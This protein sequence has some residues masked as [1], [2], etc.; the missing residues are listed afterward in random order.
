MA[1]KKPVIHARDH[2]KGGADPLDIV[3]P[4]S[5]YSNAIINEPV[6]GLV[7]YWKLDELGNTTTDAVDS[8]GNGHTGTYAIGGGFSTTATHPT[9]G[10]AA[11]ADGT[12]ASFDG[13]LDNVGIGSSVPGIQAFGEM[14][15]ECWIETEQTSHADD[16]IH[17]LDT[18]VG[19]I[20]MSDD[21]VNRFFRLELV[22]STGKLKFTVFD[23]GSVSASLTSTTVVNDGAR[24]YIV[25]TYDGT[26]MNIYIDGALDATSAPGLDGLSVN[27]GGLWVGSSFWEASNFY[28]H[29]HFQGVIDEFALYTVALPADSVETHFLIGSTAS[30]PPSGTAG[31]DLTGNYP[32]P[33]LVDIGDGAETVGDSTHYPIVTIDDKGRVTHM[34]AQSVPS[35]A[36]SGAAG[37]AL[38]GTYPNPGIAASVAG[39]GLAESSDVLSVNVD[40]STIEINSD[41]LRVKDSGI[42]AAKLSLLV[43]DLLAAVARVKVSLGGV[44]KGTRRQINFIAGTNITIT[45]T[46]DSSNEKV[47]VQ[48]DASGGGGGGGGVVGFGKQTADRVTSGTSYAGGID[49]LSSDFSF[50]ADGT[51]SYVVELLAPGSTVTVTQQ[52]QFALKLDSAQS[53]FMGYQTV[54]SGGPSQVI[55]A[56]GVITPAAGSHTVNVRFWLTSAANGTIYAGTSL[57]NSTILVMV[58]Q[59]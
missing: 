44:L 22:F 33:E 19:T 34:A 41:T 29:S 39:A 50:T 26:D 7:L 14:S 58:T 16:A 8:S 17:C 20:A 32:D 57:T 59:L 3:F 35:G 42:T 9:L 52:L 48:I 18:S 36:P 49:L 28:L 38:D 11:L 15:V 31:G 4:T 40:A 45:V 47:D 27:N 6:G 2:K 30:N 10:V 51:S 46:D 56:H 25:A 23:L 54:Q 13:V 5:N 55:R 37:G 24:H 53:V 21:T 43:T 12:A 1:S